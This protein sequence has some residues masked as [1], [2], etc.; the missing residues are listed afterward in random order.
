MKKNFLSLILAV[1]LLR[2]VPPA[3]A[4]QEKKV[5]RIGVVLSGT[6]ASDRSGNDS[7]KQGL[8][9]L[10]HSEGENI[11]IEY[12]YAEGKLDRLPALVAELAR[13]KV[14]VIVVQGTEPA[15]AA[16]QHTSTIP[17]VMAHVGDPV[18]RGIIASLARPGCNIT[19]LTSASPDLSG[20]RLELIKETVPRLSRVE[21]SG[22]LSAKAPRLTSRK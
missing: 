11:V 19:G 6:L 21:S 1:L 14:D 10:G 16:K 17:I 5:P 15:L 12:R 7:F 2:V 18:A 4:Q 3:Q 20:K 8:Q 22:V 9:E 13:L